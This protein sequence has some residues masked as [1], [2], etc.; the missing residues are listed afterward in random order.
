MEA[1]DTVLVTGGAGFAG[2]YVTRE[3]LDRGYRV[4]VYDVGD[5]RP[6]SRFVI[7][8]AIDTVT[9]ERGSI[10]NL[11]RVLE[12]VMKHRPQA[13]AHLGAI[14]D[15]GFLDLNPMVALKVN[16]EGTLNM[17]EAARLHGIGRVVM[18]STIA[19]I[20]RKMYEPID[21]DHPTITS[22]AGPLG[23]Y[24][25]AKVAAE[26]FAF[27]YQQSFG[28][29]TRIIRP[30]ALYGFGMSWLAPNYMKQIVEPAVLG[31]PVRL[32]TGGQMP[33]DYVHV[34]DLATLAVAVLEGPDDADRVFFAATGEPLRTCSDV[35]RIVRDLIKDSDIEIGEAWTDVDRA[36]LPFRGRISIDNARQQLGWSPRYAKLEDGV[37][38]YVDGVRAYL[39]SAGTL[40][41]RPKVDNA[42]GG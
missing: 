41:P 30:S 4:V 10:D 7:G 28:L 36:E 2:A 38:A 1:G 20:G 40:T 26:S 34:A 22:Q 11:P 27:A 32:A 35:G 25:A 3:L 19:V 8:K 9:L 5:F 23:A 15:I 21:G 37:A 31:R 42:P 33:R 6:E 13:I 18:F 39:R 17:F 29:D 24:G 14:M 16:V 12:V